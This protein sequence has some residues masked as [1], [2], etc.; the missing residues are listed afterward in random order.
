M[1]A[2][3]AV[4][5]AV[6]V[7]VV[8]VGAMAAREMVKRMTASL[9]WLRYVAK[10]SLHCMLIH[11]YTNQTVHAV[12]KPTEALQE[13]IIHVSDCLC[14]LLMA[15]T[16]LLLLADLLDCPKSLFCFCFLC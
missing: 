9:T 16:A 11:S 7:V 6:V 5:A 4:V 10:C 2:V 12:A 1:A 14:V 13:H 15:L 3:S 8:A